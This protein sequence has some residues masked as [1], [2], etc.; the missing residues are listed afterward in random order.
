[1]IKTTALLF[2]FFLSFSEGSSQEQTF[3]FGFYNLENF[4]DTEDDSTTR[5]E[6]FTPNGSRFWTEKRFNQKISRLGSAILSIGDWETVDLLGVCEVENRFCLDRLIENGGLAKYDYE[7]VHFDSPDRRGIDVALIYRSERIKLIEAENIPIHLSWNASFRTRDI[8]KAS[9]QIGGDTLHVFIN[10]WPSKYGGA[11]KTAPFRNAVAEVL[12]NRIL[13]I[14]KAHPGHRILVMGDLNAESGEECLEI[15]ESKTSM[16]SAFD[17]KLGSHKYQ[18]KWSTIDRIF[19]NQSFM[20]RFD[21]LNTGVHRAPM[22]LEAD[23]KF[24]GD[25]PKRSFVGL[26]YQDGYSDHL[27]VYINFQVSQ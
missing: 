12:A 25:K 18:N 27:P 14:S 1:M 23:H 9:F 24:L 26:K 10:H 8:L 16:V 19:V 4:F 6:E 3:L 2:L 13:E 21:I 20:E 17:H 5:D 7:V 11:L 22:L 15:L